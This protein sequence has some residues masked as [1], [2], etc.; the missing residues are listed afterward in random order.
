MNF[1]LKYTTIEK[2]NIATVEDFQYV[3][4]GEDCMLSNGIDIINS[5]SLQL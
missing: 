4:I 2:A 5:D 1:K 3:K